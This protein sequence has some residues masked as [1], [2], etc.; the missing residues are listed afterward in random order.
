MGSGFGPSQALRAGAKVR[1]SADLRLPGCGLNRLAEADHV[2]VEIANLDLANSIEAIDWPGDDGRAAR[3][4]LAMERADIFDPY[5]RV[6]RDLLIAAIRAW[7][8]AFGA[9]QA[10]PN[11]IALDDHEHRRLLEVGADRESKPVAVVL[12]RHPHVGDQE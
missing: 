2:T 4:E 1:D 3:F 6:D 12:R 9:A 5:V 10:D 8:A 7:I 11:A